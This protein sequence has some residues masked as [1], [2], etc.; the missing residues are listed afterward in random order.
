MEE[1]SKIEGLVLVIDANI[2]IA[3]FLKDSITRRLLLHPHIKVFTTDYTVDEFLQHKDFIIKRAKY[4][5]ED[6]DELAK[7]IL[8]KIKI[9]AQHNYFSKSEMAKKLIGSVDEKDIPIVALALTI[10]NKGIWTYDEH[11]N[12]VKDKIKI[13]KTKELAKY[14]FGET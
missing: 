4:S 11:F 1:T 6:F 3:A 14:M 5:K 13:W 9:T 7:I 8:P 2:I 12:V 10:E